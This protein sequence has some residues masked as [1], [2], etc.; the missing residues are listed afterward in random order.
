[1]ETEAAATLTGGRAAV[2]RVGFDASTETVS[3]WHV[4]LF[5][6]TDQ[7]P[8][9]AATFAA[10]GRLKPAGMLLH[11]VVTPERSTHECPPED[12]RTRQIAQ[13]VERA[14]AAR[15]NATAARTDERTPATVVD[16]AERGARELTA[17][18]KLLVEAAIVDGLLPRSGFL[19]VPPMII[20]AT[21]LDDWLLYRLAFAIRASLDPQPPAEALAWRPSGVAVCTSC[22]AVFIPRRRSV[23]VRCSLCSKRE[24]VPFVVGQR[25][26]LP[27]ERQSVRVPRL[28]GSVITG[29]KTTTLGLCVSCGGPFMG[30]RDAKSCQDCSN[31][32]R[33][34]RHRAA[35][36]QRG[37]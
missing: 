18:A 13:A 36:G 28:M 34:R 21:M 32:L 27:G 17:A 5:T 14:S 26:I 24:A 6:R 4:T 8:D 15:S 11:H 19:L 37:D 35:R 29:W 25:P 1:M 22:T 2:V 3:Q 10:A 30:R 16:R 20:K 23:A 12:P 9:P 31:R 33:Q 7:T